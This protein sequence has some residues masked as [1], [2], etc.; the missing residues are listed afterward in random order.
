[1]VQVMTHNTLKHSD[2]ELQKEQVR[3][4]L[5]IALK[6]LTFSEINILDPVSTG[7]MCSTKKKSGYFFPLLFLQGSHHGMHESALFHFVLIV[8][9]RLG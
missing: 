7:F 2:Y 1:M 6:T 5:F 9:S 4:Q 8:T 3:T